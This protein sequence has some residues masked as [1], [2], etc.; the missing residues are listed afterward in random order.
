MR[1]VRVHGRN[2]TSLPEFDLRFDEGPLAG[3]GLY[4]ITGP[5]GAGKST[6]LDAM[7]LALFDRTPRLTG[8]GG[9]EVGREGDEVG[10]LRANDPRSLMRRGTAE[11]VAQ[12]EFVGAD[13]RRYRASW[14]AHRARGR[15][16]GKLQTSELRLE[17]LGS[18][19]TV[20]GTKSEVLEAVHQRLGLTFDQFRR[21]VLLAQ[22]D[23]AAFLKSSADERSELLEAMTGTEIYT[24]LSR[25]A[26]EREKVERQAKEALEWQRG[27]LAILDAEERQ[28]LDARI[29]ADGESLAVVVRAQKQA[30][31][32]CQWHDE[33]AR[34][35]QAEAE[36]ESA[37]AVATKD[38]AG[39]D[40]ER[41]E[42]R[43]VE[44]I[45]DLRGPVEARDGAQ[46]R[47]AERAAAQRK[48]QEAV[49]RADEDEK[50]RRQELEAAE[51]A[52]SACREQWEGAQPALT[53]A[54]RVD[55][56]LEVEA[57]QV[58]EA[59]VQ[60]D[61]AQGE[62]QAARRDLQEC[63]TR[64]EELERRQAE[65]EEWLA[66]HPVLEPL[67]AEWLRWKQELERFTVALGEEG[68]AAR[69]AL[70]HETQRD[71]AAGALKASLAEVRS[72]EEQDVQAQ[73]AS[74]E[75][76]AALQAY[77]GDEIEAEGQEVEAR[78]EA[79][80]RL[81]GT[82]ARARDAAKG[83]RDARADEQKAEEAVR[84]AVLDHEESDRDLAAVQPLLGEAERGLRE[85][86]ACVDLAPRRADLRD[87][88]P[89][90][91]C[92][93]TEHPFAHGEVRADAIVAGMTARVAELQAQEKQH[94]ARRSS[95]A[96]LR[97]QQVALVEAS[98][99]RAE[100]IET[101]LA[102]AQEEWV[103]GALR[104]GIDLPARA[105]EAGVPDVLRSA[106]ADLRRRQAELN[107]LKR[108]GQKLVKAVQEAAGQAKKVHGELE[109]RR[110][111]R[112][113]AQAEL[114]RR[115]AELA[116]S[117]SRRD[118]ARNRREEALQAV[119]P[120]FAGRT[121]DWKGNLERRPRPFITACSNEV[122]Q[123]N[124]NRQQREDAGREL[125]ALQPAQAQA[126]LQ[127]DVKAEGVARAASLLNERRRAW[128]A[129]QEER[130]TWFEGRAVDEVTRELKVAVERAEGARSRAVLA[131]DAARQVCTK[132]RAEAEHAAVELGE[133]EREA[134][135]REAELGER[136]GGRSL[137]VVR[138]LLARDRAWIEAL[139]AK[140][141]ALKERRQ[142][143]QTR[144]AERRSR[145]EAHEA[146]E[147]P[148]LPAEGARESLATLEVER[149][150]LEESR[151]AGLARQRQDDELR[152]RAVE[153]EKDIARQ[154]AAWTVW[155]AL[156]DLIGSSD[157]KAF[158]KFAQGLT[159]D[160]LVEHANRHLA[161]L[162]RR[163]RLE[164]VPNQDL[165]LQVI[166]QDMADEVRSVNSL[167]GG[168]SFLVSLALAL[169]LASLS[170]ER[171]RV[172]SLFIDEGFGSLDSDTLEEAI[173]ALDALQ[174]D[175]RQVGV[176]SHVS[177]LAERLGVQVR[178]LPQGT[179]RSRVEVASGR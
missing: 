141:Q 47:T 177:G 159:L 16:Q 62:E 176:I 37:L 76:Q 136:L 45:Q 58:R 129:R 44:A 12:V 171:I 38:E 158:R 89:C 164:R 152:A 88:E 2:L 11:A 43:R 111:L 36:A 83:A 133:A 134:A 65:A 82:S 35:G 28:A 132:C 123:W 40:P 155:R 154:V 46:K 148:D 107:A 84:R 80:A 18:G 30:E 92:G 41:E 6:I 21:S 179:G 160:A 39:A 167:S 178:V 144:L 98:R 149:R 85:A 13:G 57:R 122:A 100:E 96:A 49:S 124:A 68:K 110:R 130:R 135:Q 125:A 81:E 105:D 29:V 15:A 146:H 156:S 150:R 117:T 166:D 48:S 163:Y 90:P 147:R 9:C 118:E 126:L 131:H 95:S 22:G 79:L 120:A 91:L 72:H 142:E 87:G 172:D 7:C 52:F 27:S 138:E 50:A 169:G 93:A 137:A 116:Q 34:L 173:A 71:Q 143:A 97:E 1:I 109:A 19:H 157:G 42:L 55:T 139:Q 69:E 20:E 60:L 32:A 127:V 64:V 23:F 61:Q 175:G 67:A 77:R 113:E 121:D 66:G 10:R 106:G 54:R 17:E 99:R 24:E 5:T 73:Q 128:E 151:H 170:A 63:V 33:L 31:K 3:T 115:E 162:A 4:A 101:V 103:L 140:L 51:V 53:E 102:R 112:D 108:T 145:R 114:T 165:D 8:L 78:L 25:A 59:E 74:S 168:E 75:A 94:L 161:T 70:Q 153:L 26:H 14:K 119:E 86:R 104:I 174:S 56:L